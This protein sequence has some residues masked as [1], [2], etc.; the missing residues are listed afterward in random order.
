MSIPESVCALHGLNLCEVFYCNYIRKKPPSLTVRMCVA[1]TAVSSTDRLSEQL[2]EIL[3]RKK[4]V[5]NSGIQNN[6]F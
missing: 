5:W 1:L 6:W 4:D 2:P 3:I